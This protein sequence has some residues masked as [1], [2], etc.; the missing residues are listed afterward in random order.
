MA[1][2]THMVQ[3]YRWCRAL[4]WLK[5]LMELRELQKAEGAPTQ[6][7]IAEEPKSSESEGISA[8]DDAEKTTPPEYPTMPNL[9]QPLIM[10]KLQSIGDGRNE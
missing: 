6:T 3:G 5:T 7:Q 1:E 10:R 9:W 4:P 2:G 8:P